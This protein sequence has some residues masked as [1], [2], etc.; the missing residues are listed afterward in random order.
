MKLDSLLRKAIFPSVLAVAASLA[1]I[2]SAPLAQAEIVAHW[3]FN[4]SAG[5]TT[6][7]DATGAYDATAT[8]ASITF[9]E[10]GKFGNAVTFDGSAG[11]QLVF[12]QLAGIYDTDLTLA[13]WVK[14]SAACGTSAQIIGAWEKAHSFRVYAGGSEQGVINHSLTLD[15]RGTSDTNFPVAAS[16]LEEDVWTHVAFTVNRATGT[17]TSY[18]NGVQSSTKTYANLE[19][20]KVSTGQYGIGRKQDGGNYGTTGVWN[21]SLDE[22]FVM[23][24]ALTI[25]QIRGL[26]ASNNINEFVVA[27]PYAQTSENVLLGA[28]FGVSSE[29]TVQE[30]MA[31]GGSFGAKASEA[32]LGVARIVAGSSVKLNENQDVTGDGLQMNLSSLTAENTV[33]QGYQTEIQNAKINVTPI[34]MTGKVFNEGL[35]VG[36]ATKTYV[37]QGF[38]VDEGIGIHGN[39]LITFDLAEIR[40]ANGWSAEE[41]LAFYC[42]KAGLNDSSTGTIDQEIIVSDANQ[43]VLGSYVNGKFMAMEEAGGVYS[44][45]GTKPASLNGSNRSYDVNLALPANAKYLTLAVT[46]ATGDISADHGVFAQAQ[47]VRLNAS[48]IYLN[49]LFDDS[50]KEGTTNSGTL[51]AAMSTNTVG[52]AATLNSAGIVGFQF[53]LNQAFSLASGASWKYDFR[54]NFQ[55]CE[56]LRERAPL[57]SRCAELDSTALNPILGTLASPKDFIAGHSEYALTFDLNEIR[58]MG[59]LGDDQIFRFTA[60]ATGTHSSSGAMT[61]VALVSN[62][63]GLQGGYVNGTYY[64]AAYDAANDAWGLEGLDPAT[65][66]TFTGAETKDFDVILRGDSKFLTLAL[67]AAKA[68]R[69]SDHGAWLNPMLTLVS[70]SE[71]PEPSSLILLV[72]GLLGLGAFCRFRPNTSVHSF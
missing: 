65:I 35:T 22:M 52:A 32:N 57:N 28:L 12:N 63:D 19:N 30:A 37:N 29:K 53:N 48:E 8:N 50:F 1:G 51:D 59:G 68:D 10:A 9:G 44:F 20:L 31:A 72:S 7:A 46:E 70:A 17:L 45:A 64:P 55:V 42:S 66:L 49:R 18:V 23:T 11:S 25:P 47:L 60:A 26:I 56:S 62:E 69:T 36:T 41:R 6:A 71:V 54:K 2:P 16:G 39:G 15:F 33:M 34:R 27:A 13:F 14:Q 24:D 43:N 38:K 4:E 61:A 3:T 58:A 5:A 67:L 21:G 40:A